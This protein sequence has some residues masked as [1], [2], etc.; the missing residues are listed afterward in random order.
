MIY[1]DMKQLKRYRGLNSHLDT[2][3]AYLE[4]TGIDGL[5][6]GRNEVDGDNVYI[7]R[8]RYTTM[9]V[10]QA[11]F[12]AHEVYADIHL[13]ESGRELIGV[14]PIDAL[15]ITGTDRESDNVECSGPVE[16]MVPMEPGKVLIVFPEDAHMVKIQAGE[17][18]NVEKAVVKVRMN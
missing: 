11:A 5:V 1:T 9:A 6:P 16:A 8:F 2:A 15:E 14:T 17:P 7:N 12:E 13:L 18:V 10:E 3:I 4:E